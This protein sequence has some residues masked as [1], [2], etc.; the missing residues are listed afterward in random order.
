MKCQ[1]IL[2][3]ILLAVVIT[4][5]LPITGWLT[6]LTAYAQS[7]PITIY[8][9]L[10]AT[11]D[12]CTM[13]TQEQQLADLIRTAPGQGRAAFTCN[14]TLAAVAAAQARDMA[15]RGYINSIDPEGY[16]PNYRVR[17]AG[18]PLPAY[19]NATALGNNIESIF[20]G[21]S[22]TDEVWAA[23]VNN[24]QLHGRGDFWAKQTEF[25]IAY[26]RDPASPMGYYWVI[27][28]AP[29]TS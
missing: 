6:P 3:S 26:Y 2:S 14:S 18:Y 8:L 7:T 29:P 21:Y 23:A 10:V 4:L 9:P 5:A 12:G 16:G 22:S 15:N 20:A 28:T 17:Q 24:D 1:S 19:Y 27:I 25:G 13:N 11:T